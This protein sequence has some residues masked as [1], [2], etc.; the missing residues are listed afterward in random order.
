MPTHI[1]SLNTVCRFTLCL[2][3]CVCVCLVNATLPH[4][5]DFAR[6]EKIMLPNLTEEQV[7]GRIRQAVLDGETKPRAYYQSHAPLRLP[8]VVE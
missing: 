6:K 8:T 5:A 7:E 2:C 4:C 1:F 3:V